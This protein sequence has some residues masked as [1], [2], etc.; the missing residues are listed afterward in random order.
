MQRIAARDPKALAALYQRYS[1][2]VMG[3]CLRILNDRAE[4]EEAVE[5][6][7]WELWSKPDRYDPQRGAV[8]TF[9][10]TLTHSR[11]LDRLRSLRRTRALSLDA[12]SDD[13]PGS[14]PAAPDADPSHAVMLDEAR[15]RVRR[16]LDALEPDQRKVVELA[17]LEGL[18]HSEIAQRLSQPLGTVK[19]RIRAGLSR[20]RH[21]LRAIYSEVNEP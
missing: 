12:R 16:S 9:L 21:S 4:A 17:F 7:F 19:T 2:C 10:L 6:I 20:L 11:V 3:H 5:Q 18:S 14:S 13:A 1:S 15:Q 8:L